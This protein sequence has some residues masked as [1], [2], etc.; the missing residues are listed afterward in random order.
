M[1]K[2]RLSLGL[3]IDNCPLFVSSAIR[4]IIKLNILF[5]LLNNSKAKFVTIGQ[6]DI[7]FFNNEFILS[8]L[9]CK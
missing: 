1:I 3:Y 8:Y 4:Y 9:R 2:K 7:T 6:I 5:G